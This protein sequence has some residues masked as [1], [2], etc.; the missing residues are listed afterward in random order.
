MTGPEMVRSSAFKFTAAG[1][2]HLSIAPAEQREAALLVIR[3]TGTGI[4]PDRLGAIFDLFTQGDSSTTRRYDGMGMGLTLVQRC[5]E[6]LGGEVMVESEP[7]HGSV[8][9]VKLPG[10]LAKVAEQRRPPPAA[11]VSRAYQ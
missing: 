11:G 2:V 10:A 7:G 3:D 1:E 8:F 5:V 9:R 4:A 6:L